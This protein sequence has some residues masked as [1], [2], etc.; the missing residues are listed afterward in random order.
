[1]TELINIIQIKEQNAEDEKY[2]EFTRQAI[3]LYLEIFSDP[4]YYEHFEF[5]D[6][7]KEFYQYINDG[8]F[9]L[10]IIDNKSVGFI[11]SSN[12]LEH[13]SRTIEERMRLDGIN[14]ERDTYIS[15]LGVSAQHRG[16]GIAKKL[17]DTFMNINQEKNMFLRTGLHNNDQVIRL[18]EKYGFKQTDITEDVTSQ[19]IN[20]EFS[21]D[22]RFYMIKI[23][24]MPYFDKVNNDG[25]DGDTDNKDNDEYN[26]D[27]NNKNNDGYSSGSENLYGTHGHYNSN[28]NN[29]DNDGYSSGSENLYG[30]HGYY[31]GDTNNQDNEEH[32]DT[33]YK[34]GS[35]DMY[36]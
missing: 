23:P 26:N 29:Q 1:M 16:K 36:G 5:T 24:K 8:C 7:E 19:R 9:I 21:Y 6:I 31:N 30:S 10:A 3:N 2:I 28:T 25:Y 35:E 20:G 33:G 15:E 4:P 22:T 27:T 12:G 18:Y 34:S 11:C 17:I 13:I 32:D 14:C